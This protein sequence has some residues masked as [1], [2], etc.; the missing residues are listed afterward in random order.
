MHSCNCH[1]ISHPRR[2]FAKTPVFTR[3]IQHP[4][5]PAASHLSPRSREHAKYCTTFL[6]QLLLSPSRGKHA[7]YVCAAHGSQVTHHGAPL[8][9]PDA[10]GLPPCASRCRIATP[11]TP[12]HLDRRRRL[13]P[14]EWRDPRIF[15]RITSKP[16][17]PNHIPKRDLS[18]FPKA[19]H[20]GTQPAT[21][22]QKMPR[23]QQSQAQAWLHTKRAIPLS[24]P[25]AGTERNLS[26]T[27]QTDRAVE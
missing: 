8:P 5:P 20:T 24:N 12:R 1:A 7:G 17:T 3:E 21:P 25:G 4:A 18:S 22:T 2:H 13:L 11:F 14:P 6:P 27:S 9:D 26:S 16:G 23:T 10:P 15:H 19:F